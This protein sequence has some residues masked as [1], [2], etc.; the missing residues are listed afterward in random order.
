[1]LVC[2][3]RCHFWVERGQTH[4]NAFCM[5][6]SQYDVIKN[7]LTD[8]GNMITCWKTIR[9]ISPP[10]IMQIW[11]MWG[12]ENIDGLGKCGIKNV[13]FHFHSI[14]YLRE[15]MRAKRGPDGVRNSPIGPTW[16]SHSLH[17]NRQNYG[18]TFTGLQTEYSASMLSTLCCLIGILKKKKKK[19]IN[20]TQNVNLN[21]LKHFSK[22]N[23][24]GKN[25]RKSLYIDKGVT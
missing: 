1:M 2:G 7:I 8:R 15:K 11:R 24:G 13:C 21:K 18:K 12:W 17:Q 23:H 25:R 5:E 3:S 22:S 19:T 16:L 6:L 10:W 20:R 9:Q 14:K 4:Y